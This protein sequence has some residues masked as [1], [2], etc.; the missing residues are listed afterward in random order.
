MDNQADKVLKSISDND[1][2]TFKSLL[3]TQEA[4]LSLIDGP[5]SKEERDREASTMEAALGKKVNK[6]KLDKVIIDEIGSIRNIPCLLHL[7]SIGALA[8]AVPSI[9]V[10]PLSKVYS[11]IRNETFLFILD[12]VTFSVSDTLD[13][14]EASIKKH[15]HTISRSLI[16]SLPE[17]YS[18]REH[19]RRFNSL[20]AT[21]FEGNQTSI[22]YDLLEKYP[23]SIDETGILE[24]A[25]ELIPGDEMTFE[26]STSL[27]D[28]PCTTVFS[29]IDNKLQSKLKPT[30]TGLKPTKTGLKPTK[31]GLNHK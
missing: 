14:L 9:M 1:I 5:P 3:P 26:K 31:T 16:E 25:K 20:L 28:L 27:L 4:F 24:Q 18:N 30:K 13:L 23:G 29:N 12:H 19:R 11:P 8:G 7:N 22:I 17:D 21:L 10:L 2:D 6:Q 15:L